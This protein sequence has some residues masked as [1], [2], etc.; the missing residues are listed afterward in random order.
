M[1]GLDQLVI[2][3][4]WFPET[5]QAEWEESVWTMLEASFALGDFANG[6][7]DAGQYL[8]QIESIGI[9]PLS[10]WDVMDGQPEC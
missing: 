10:L 7:I 9:D 2:P 5:S 6:H 1:P 4:L 3:A 8:D